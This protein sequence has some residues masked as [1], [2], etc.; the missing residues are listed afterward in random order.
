M[1]MI[2]G[3]F[4]GTALVLIA[5][6]AMADGTLTITATS[7]T[8][9]VTAPAPVAAPA[10]PNGEAGQAA[11]KNKNYAL[12]AANFKPLADAGD[13]EAQRM[14]GNFLMMKCTG[15][16]D[17][18]AGA[19]WLQ[20]AADSGDA[21]AAGQL[22]LAYMNGQGVA[23]DDN[24]AFALLNKAAQAGQAPAMVNLGYLYL[25]GRGV[26]KDLYQGMFW[27]AKGGEQGL[28]AALSNIAQGYF[29]G[30]ALP[31]DNDKAAFF[32]Q[33]AMMRST[34]EQRA[35]FVATSNN[36]IRAMSP[37][38]FK[39]AGAKAQRWSPGKGSLSDVVDDAASMQKKQAKN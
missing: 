4:A 24:K 7:T 5:G 14:Y 16:E 6:S 10:T 33:L 21:I 38:D 17:D 20:K 27:S 23:Q 31:Q 34:P 18:A 35:R 37:E 29:K 39:R 36:I 22:G 32:I 25:S 12:A 13:A 1:G 30:Q 19:S 2:R 8:C 15:L 3:L 26:P 28:P 11:I 9:Q